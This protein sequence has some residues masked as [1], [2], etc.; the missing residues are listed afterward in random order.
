MVGQSR[1]SRIQ[2]A[3]RARRIPP[4]GC[5]PPVGGRDVSPACRCDSVL[6]VVGLAPWAGR[7]AGPPRSG[8]RRGAPAPVP[9]VARD[10]RSAPSSRRSRLRRVPPDEHQDWARGR[11]SRMIQPATAATALGDFSQTRL[12]APRQALSS[13][14]RERRRALHHRIVADRKARR[15]PRRVH[16]RQPP[17][18]ALPHH[19]RPRPHRRAAADVGRRAAR[20]V[21]QRGHHPAGRAARQPGAAVEQELCRL[22]RQRAGEPLLAG[23]AD[24][25]DDVDGLRHLVRAVPWPGQRPRREVR[26]LRGRGD[27]WRHGHRPT[28]AARRG[29][30]QHG[31]RAVPLAARRSGARVSCRR[32]LLRLLRAEARIHAAQRARSGVLGRRPTAPL[33]ERRDRAVAEPLLPEGRRHVRHLPRPA[34]ARRRSPPGAGAG[35]QRSVHA[36]SPGHRR[37]THDA[38]AA[39]GVERR[40]LVR[41]VPHAEGRAQHQG[42]DS[43]SLDQPAH[44]REHGRV[45]HPERVHRMSHHEVAA[46]GRWRPWRS[47]GRTGGGPA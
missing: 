25:R 41:R 11:H 46:P 1:R 18:P 4:V 32:R 9:S 36:V 19:H 38:H 31:V 27:G 40:Q 39:P 34:P 29:L 44:S 13:S 20:V 16:A 12:D 14:R 45:R 10:G 33:L 3:E 43:R 47:G 24:L 6:L 7:R 21:R 35:E 17:H 5:R 8:R 22:P 42:E 26:R 28:H 2:A 30:E 15:A 37:P 23:H